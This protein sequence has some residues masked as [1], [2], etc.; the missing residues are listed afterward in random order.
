MRKLDAEQGLRMYR[1][2]IAS[3]GRGEYT[4]RRGTRPVLEPDRHA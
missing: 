1:Q 3:D 2:A 4:R